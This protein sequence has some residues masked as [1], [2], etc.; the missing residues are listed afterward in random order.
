VTVVGLADVKTEAVPGE[1]Y[2]TAK[3][4]GSSCKYRLGIDGVDVATQPAP[5]C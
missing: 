2:V 1:F 5:T 4:S 3:V